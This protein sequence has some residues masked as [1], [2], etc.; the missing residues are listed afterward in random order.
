[1]FAEPD[2]ILHEEV[3]AAV[4]DWQMA[5]VKSFFHVLPLDEAVGRLQRGTLPPRA[6]AITFDDGY[7]DN[8]VVA[9]PILKRHRLPATFFIATDFLDGGR[10]W[11]DSIIE[12]FR[13]APG[14][15]LDLVHL[16]LGRHPIG[17]IPQRRTAIDAVIAQVKYRS[18]KARSE[19]VEALR[20]SAAVSL[21]T[22]L[23]MSSDQVR[24]LHR[25]GMSIGGH[26][27]SHPILASLSEEEAREEIIVGRQV[28][29]D[30]IGEPVALFA[31]PNGRPGAD[32][33]GRHARLVRDAGF[34]A[35][36]TTSWGAARRGSDIFQLPRFTPWDRSPGRFILRLVRNAMQ[37][38]IS[39]PEAM[40]AST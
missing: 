23:M 29:A 27:R 31:Y 40:P 36:V 20:A 8:T 18:A 14:D 39:V 37:G 38:G 30:I 2:S 33:D 6:I 3:N 28:L 10:M 17:T 21:P 12:T 26:T 25:S 24:A 15:V 9:L 4:F 5:L 34:A 13:R 35:A 32:Y 11:N 22:N 19:V 7:A 1:V 16:G